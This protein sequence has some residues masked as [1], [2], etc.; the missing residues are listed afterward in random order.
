M[1]NYLRV[2]GVLCPL[3]AREKRG[4]EWSKVALIPIAAIMGFGFIVLLISL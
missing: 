4:S 2:G 1:I 3:E